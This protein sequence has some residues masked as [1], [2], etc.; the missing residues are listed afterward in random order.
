MTVPND[1]T[2]VKNL[3]AL[4]GYPL[5]HTFSPPYFNEKFE[6]ESIA[7]SHYIAMPLSTIEELPEQL[8]R[9]SNLKGMNVTLPYKQSVMAYLD[10]HSD[11]AQRI[12][13]VNTIQFKDGKRIGHNTDAIGFESSLKELIQNVQQPLLRALVLGNGGA[14]Q[15]VYYVLDKL[16]IP[17]Q[18]V[19][20]SRQK[21][22]LI[23]SDINEGVILGH[24]L[25]INTTPLGMS[26]HINTA[27]DLPYHALHAGHYLYDL[28]YNPEETLFLQQGKKQGAS[29]MNGLKMLYLQAEAA[30]KIWNE[31]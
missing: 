22:D 1:L 2:K 23:Y 12:G 14:A 31:I 20:R 11:G 4:I 24:S 5:S 17:Y 27:P 21:G 15:A 8:D 6:R 30:W 10:E 29:I 9:Y 16:N 18:K 3:Y 7:D 19:S 25:I 28:V 13:A 26:P